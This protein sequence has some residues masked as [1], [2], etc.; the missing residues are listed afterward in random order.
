LTKNQDRLERGREKKAPPPLLHFRLEK[1]QLKR[2]AFEIEKKTWTAE[3]LR[4]RQTEAYIV[5]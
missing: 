1:L 2:F 3:K 5:S 4:R